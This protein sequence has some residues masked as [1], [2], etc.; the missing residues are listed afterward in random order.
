[1]GIIT[2]VG[3]GITITHETQLGCMKSLLWYKHAAS[4]NP[5][6]W[7]RRLGSRSSSRLALIDGS[8]GVSEEGFALDSPVALEDVRF[9][10]AFL[11][12]A[13]VVS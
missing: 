3:N 2:P 13:P 11:G 8:G 9:A 12:H 5:E 4:S 1:M 10:L 6:T 7:E